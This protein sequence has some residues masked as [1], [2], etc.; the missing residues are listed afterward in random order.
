MR[1]RGVNIG[2]GPARVICI[3]GLI[4]ARMPTLFAARYPRFT[5][6]HDA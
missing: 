6:R 1:K 3:S 2:T 4:G 5:V